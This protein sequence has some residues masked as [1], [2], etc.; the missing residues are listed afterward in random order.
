MA[1]LVRADEFTF[2]YEEFAGQ[3][4]EL[5]QQY[6]DAAER[7]CPADIWGA[8]QKLAVQLLASHN[9]AMRLVS[10]GQMLG[11]DSRSAG[12]SGLEG[13]SYG[14]EYARM[15]SLLPTTGFAF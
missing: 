13:S 5:I 6:L 12:G 1:P 7:Q 14:Q 2:L 8:D 3:P 4:E 11:V 9:L 15:R 10:V